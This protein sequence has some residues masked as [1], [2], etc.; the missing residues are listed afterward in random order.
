MSVTFLPYGSDAMEWAEDPVP[1]IR[2]VFGGTYPGD[3]PDT[4][5]KVVVLVTSVSGG[6]S[7]ASIYGPRASVRDYLERCPMFRPYRWT[8]D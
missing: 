3:L 2:G 6:S 5:G 7:W 1:T 4:Y 8:E